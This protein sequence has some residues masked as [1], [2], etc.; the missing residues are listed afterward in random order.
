[1]HLLDP[2]NAY[3]S[4]T[5]SILQTTILNS[6]CFIVLLRVFVKRLFGERTLNVILLL[7]FIT[8]DFNKRIFATDVTEEEEEELI[9]EVK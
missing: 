2:Q 1:M 8:E 5:G 4:K 9:K 7:L 3:F 6:F